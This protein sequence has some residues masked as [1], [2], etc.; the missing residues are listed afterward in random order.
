M[1]CCCLIDEQSVARV[2]QRLKHE[3]FFGHSYAKIFAAMEALYREGLTVEAT[4]VADRLKATHMLHQIGGIPTLSGLITEVPNAENL[5]AYIDIVYGRYTMRSLL[6]AC[7]DIEAEVY[8]S[9]NQN[10][11]GVLE[12]AENKLFSITSEIIKKDTRPARDILWDTFSAIEKRAKLGG[13]VPGIQ[14]GF[15]TLDRMTGGFRP[16]QLIIVAGRPGMGKTSLAVNWA[17]EAAI[18]H[19][20]GVA[21]F[22]LEMSETELMER[23]LSSIA[24]VPSERIRAGVLEDDDYQCMSEAGGLIVES[25]IHINDMAGLSPIELKAHV[26]RLMSNV[27]VDMVIVDYLQLMHSGIRGLAGNK[28]AETT[29]ISRSLKI[30]ARELNVPIIA[31]SQ[32][33]RAPERRDDPRPILSDLRE[34][35]AIEQDAD[36]VMFVFREELYKSRMTTSMVEDVHGKAELIVRKQRN[37]PTGTIPLAFE[38]KFTRFRELATVGARRYPVEERSGNDSSG[39][40]FFDA[41]DRSA[42]S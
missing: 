42:D 24:N 10:P 1:L 38:P 30:I 26:R 13:R 3:H 9:G 28:V 40:D 7:S 31:L 22:S 41:V 34:S 17:T 18:K 2:M 14:T 20:T 35:G 36:I 15:D 11:K 27:D 29:E 4:T 19:G 33:S 16:G 23:M 6:S 25:K 5:D 8:K 39:G 12:H 21:M 32:L 37:G